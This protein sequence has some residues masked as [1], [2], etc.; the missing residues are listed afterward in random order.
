M[1]Q[2]L[3]HIIESKDLFTFKKSKSNWETMAIIR[4]PIPNCA[5]ATE[6]VDNA[7]AA[8]LLMVHNNI[9]VI[10]PAAAVPQ[11]QQRAPKLD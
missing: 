11:L 3:Y 7:V 1:N 2:H 6:D 4:C 8:A 5:Y 9:H 10:Q